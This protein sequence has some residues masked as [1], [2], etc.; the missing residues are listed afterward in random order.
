MILTFFSSLDPSELTDIDEMDDDDST[1][2]ALL[3]SDSLE[4]HLEPISQPIQDHLV[5]LIYNFFINSCTNSNSLFLSNSAIDTDWITSNRNFLSLL[6][7]PER[8]RFF[9]TA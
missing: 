8:F 5:L 2:A 4:L 9:D 1:E 7:S 6:A 3:S